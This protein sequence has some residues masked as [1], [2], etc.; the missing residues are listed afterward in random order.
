MIVARH[1]VPGVKINGFV[2]KGREARADEFFDYLLR[3]NWR[4]QLRRAA[5]GPYV[6][7]VSTFG[8]RHPSGRLV[9]VV[10]S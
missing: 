5:I 8:W 6:R 4:V 10:G 3:R 2:L 9:P 1:A 7:F